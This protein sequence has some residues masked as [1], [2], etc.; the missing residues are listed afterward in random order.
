MQAGEGANLPAAAPHIAAQ[1]VQ[2]ASQQDTMHAGGSFG[3]IHV[4]LH[5]RSLWAFVSPTH[6]L[7]VKRTVMVFF[8][9]LVAEVLAAPIALVTSPD[10]DIGFCGGTDLKW[11]LALFTIAGCLVLA[12]LPYW[13]IHVAR[14]YIQQQMF[15]ASGNIPQGPQPATEARAG[16]GAFQEARLRRDHTVYLALAAVFLFSVGLFGFKAAWPSESGYEWTPPFVPT[17]P[18]KP[19][20]TAA[21]FA[22]VCSVVSLGFMSSMFVVF[23]NYLE[24][25]RGRP[26]R[27]LARS[28]DF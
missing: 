20:L 22:S 21:R 11:F 9:F 8:A 1:N 7:I 16:A 26:D 5:H 18:C 15:D 24:W 28:I 4:P 12:A 14:P 13:Y 25:R 10:T 6:I 2:Q 23:Y 3:N 17:K 19:I 27:D